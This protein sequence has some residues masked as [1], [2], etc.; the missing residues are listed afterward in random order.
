[1]KKTIIL[2]STIFCFIILMSCSNEDKNM[3]QD[4]SA[5]EVKFTVANFLHD[6]IATRTFIK[7]PDNI[8]GN[9]AF[10]WEDNDTIGIIPTIGSQIYFTV[11]RGAQTDEA[12]FDGGAW[13]MKT[14]NSIKYA[15]YYPFVHGHNLDRA[16]MEVDYTGQNF[17][18]C[19][20]HEL[21]SISKYDYMISQPR[22]TQ[23]TRYIL[24]EFKH[25]NSLV[26]FQFS[27]P[28]GTKIKKIDVSTQDKA[29]VFALRGSYDIDQ[30]IDGNININVDEQDKTNVFTVKTDNVEAIND[31]ISVFCMMPPTDLSGKKVVIDVTTADDTKTTIE[32]ANK[33][34]NMVSGKWYT[35]ADQ[36]M[37][38]NLNSLLK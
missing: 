32:C 18:P 4:N 31:S 2:L 16:R 19:K 30:A 22:N 15:A 25:I 36:K 34:K 29:K 1:M 21:T 37:L 8:L 11:S 27:L 33:P 12:G 26:E 5:K 17:E 20:D 38:D 6:N 23:G 14:D 3:L 28:T 24:F 35:L 10:R 13:N 9:T 7:L